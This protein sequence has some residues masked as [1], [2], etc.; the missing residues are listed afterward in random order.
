MLSILIPVYNYGV[1]LLV[2]N[3]LIQLESIDCRWEI[4]L[5]D[6]ASNEEWIKQNSK[7]V[8]KLNN[9][10]IKLFQ[11][12]INVGNAANRNFLI[13]QAS[14]DWLLFLDV[15]VI[16]VTFNFLSIYKKKMQSISQEIIAGNILYDNKNPLPHLLRWKYGKAREQILFKGGN[17]NIILNIRGANFAI[18]KELAVKKNFPILKEK[19][20][21]IDTRFFLQFTKSQIYFINN[22]V[23]HLGIEENKVFLEKTKKAIVNA[24]FL[25]NQNEKLS[26]QIMLISIYKKIRIFKRILAKIYLRCH[27]SFEKNIMSKKPSILIFQAYKILYISYLDTFKNT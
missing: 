10:Q 1:Q 23:Y 4:L 6:D 9:S 11:Q 2:E 19:Y 3:L 12:E 13:A 15:D 18:K 26:K 21:F 20:G 16:P 24:L 22:S 14:Y 27:F 25:L 8:S 5:S 7:F 17:K